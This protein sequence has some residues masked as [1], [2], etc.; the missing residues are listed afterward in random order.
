MINALGL[1][2]IRLMGGLC[3]SIL[4]LS[5]TDIKVLIAYSSVGHMRLSLGALMLLNDAGVLASF[6]ITFAHGLSSAGM[7][8][9]ANLVYLKA[10]TRNLMLLKGLLL[11]SPSLCLA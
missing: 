4:C 5:Q 9:C 3:A 11:T 1:S 2:N 10:S 8:S 6:L 7:F